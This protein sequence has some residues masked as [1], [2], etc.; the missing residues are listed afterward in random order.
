[1]GAR[2]KRSWLLLLWCIACSAAPFP[3]DAGSPPPDAG[4]QGGGSVDAGAADSGTLDSGLPDAGPLLPDGGV[5]KSASC[6][7]TFGNALTAGFARLDGTVLAVVPPNDQLCA[8]PNSTHLVIQLLMN[9][10]AYRMVVDVLSNQGN[11]DVFF[12]EQDHALLG[13]AWAEGWHDPSSLDYLQ[14]LG[15]HSTQ[16]TETNEADVVAKI[17]SELTLG[18][19]LSVFAT[20]GTTEPDS[21]HLVHRNIPHMDGA[22]VIDPDGATPHW[23]FIRFDEQVF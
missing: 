7:A 4:P 3:G 16:F 9:G 18:A 23:L 6:A 13:G 14:D 19:H 1:M 21:A 17:T 20:A 5:D 22:I 8:A 15:L 10:A 11:P 2:V 12:F